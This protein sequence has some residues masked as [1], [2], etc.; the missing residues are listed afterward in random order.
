M[1]ENKTIFLAILQVVFFLV[2]MAQEYPIIPKPEQ[3]IYGNDNLRLDKD[4]GI[5]YEGEND[6]IQKTLEVFRQQL[7]KVSGLKVVSNEKKT[8]NIQVVVRSDEKQHEEGYELDIHPQGIAITAKGHAGVFYALQTLRQLLPPIRNNDRIVLRTARIIDAPAIDWRGMML[9][10][11]RHFYPK[12]SILHLLDL[13][14]LYKI[15]V[16]H[17]HLCDNEGWRLEIKKYPK[18]TEI[19]AWRDEVYG[20]QFY[21]DD[22]TLNLNDTYRYGGFY[23]QQEIREVVQYAAERHITILPEIELPGHSGAVLA[24]YPELSCNGKAQAVP[25]KTAMGSLANQ[26][27]YNFEFCAGKEAPFEFLESVLDEVI[28]LFPS[29]YIHIGGD[30]VDKTHWKNCT[31]CQRRMQKENLKDEEELQSYFVKRI[32]NFL[33]KN[34]RHLIGWD[35]ILEGGLP[36]SST[37]MS[38][39]GEKGGIKAAQMGHDVIMSPSDPL[40]LNRYQD[41]PAKEPLAVKFSINTLDNVYAYSPYA[42]LGGETY[43]KFIKGVQFAIWTEFIPS[44]EHLEYMMLPRL[45]AFAEA[46]WTKPEQKDVDGFVRRLNGGHY[47]RWQQTGIRFHHE[48]FRQ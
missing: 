39:R 37:V 30:E 32:E 47:Q 4:I 20:S 14:A 35:E 11:S 40:Y 36:V 27:R 18:L 22:S 16:F 38:W 1:R 29:T 46:T 28:E 7:Q 48:L 43:H 41:D 44:L 21:K 34:N 31:Y 12:E 13:L 33:A 8:V 5:L 10:V 6:T 42:N 17:W 9:D 2:G 24:A 23:T 19:G 15:N 3:I 45:P 25:N 26:Q